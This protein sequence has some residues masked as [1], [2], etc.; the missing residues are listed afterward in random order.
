MKTL[1]LVLFALA[2]SAG[3]LLHAAP[4]NSPETTNAFNKEIQQL[5]K[6]MDIEIEEDV[7]A[8]ILIRFNEENEMQVLYV[9]TVNAKAG[10][11]IKKH[12]NH[13]RIKTILDPSIEKYKLPIRLKS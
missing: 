4:E 3:S 1:K 5:L 13:K 9:G 11:L 12:L 8:N 2:I 10:K 6:N 7:V